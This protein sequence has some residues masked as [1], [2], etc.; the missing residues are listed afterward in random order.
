MLL[1][2]RLTCGHQASPSPARRQRP[3]GTPTRPPAHE[4]P[5]H[6]RFFPGQVPVTRRSSAERLGAC[7]SVKPCV[8]A[9]SVTSAHA[10]LRRLDRIMTQVAAGPQRDRHHGKGLPLGNAAGSGPS[11]ESRT[12]TASHEHGGIDPIVSYRARSR[13]GHG[14]GIR[15]SHR[16]PANSKELFMKKIFAARPAGAR[17][18]SAG[19]SRRV[20]WERP[21]AQGDG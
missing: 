6:P 11:A 15:Q 17:R 2:A 5:N 12:L 8:H 3:L 7:S 9:G 21:R 20:C 10:L 13:D 1:C 18:S 19:H 4:R 14:G 16:L